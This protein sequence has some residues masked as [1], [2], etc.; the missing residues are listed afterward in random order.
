MKRFLCAVFFIFPYI[1]LA[2]TETLNWYVEGINYA[3]TTCQTGADIIL[4]PPPTKYGYTFRGWIQYTPIEYLQ[5]S[6]NQY[7]DT[8]IVPDLLTRIEVDLKLDAAAEP[9]LFGIL[10]GTGGGR[11]F[12][13]NFG[14]PNQ[15]L[16]LYP[17]LCR[18]QVTSNCR[19]EMFSINNQTKTTRNT[20]KLDLKNKRASYGTYTKN[21][22]Q[23]VTRPNKTIYLFGYHTVSSTGVEG[24]SLGSMYVYAARIYENDVLV[25]E[26]IPVLDINDTPCMYEKIT[27]TFFYN[28]GTGDFIAGPTL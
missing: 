6:G 3:T 23:P 20:V 28:G 8:G 21:L 4:P 11:T 27:D 13:M 16:N 10:D 15:P 18:Y 2:D 26:F 7:I 24:A 5:S 9:A 17:W 19:A 14:A 12:G 25:R 1:A 22:T